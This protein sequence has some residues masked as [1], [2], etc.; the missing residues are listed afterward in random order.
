MGNFDLMAPRTEVSDQVKR[1]V[2][3]ALQ[4]TWFEKPDSLAQ[5]LHLSRDEV[6]GALA[7]WTQAGRAIY[8]AHREVYRVRELRREPL[9]MEDLRFSNEREASAQDLMNLGKVTVH[10]DDVNGF[11][12]LTGKVQDGKHTHE[13]VL[14]IDEDQRLTHGECTCNFHKQNK[15]RQGPCAHLLAIRMTHQRN[16]QPVHAS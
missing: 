11:I 6:M 16:R 3:E 1:R 8:D 9:P 4:E 12:R 5:R 7:A 15:L 14:H 2:F 13:I 10:G